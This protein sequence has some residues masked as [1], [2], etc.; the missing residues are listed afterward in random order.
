M[1]NVTKD[2]FIKRAKAVHGDKYD[3]SQVEYVN[4]QIPVTIVCPIHGSF[5]QR[6][7][8]HMLGRGCRKCGHIKRREKRVKTTSQF[9]EDARKVHGDKYDYS[10]VEYVNNYTDVK[11]VCPKHGV[12]SQIPHVH[13]YGCGCP[14]CR[15]VMNGENRKFTT[16]EFIHKA[17]MKHGDR[18]DYSKVIYSNEKEKVEIICKEHGSFW[19]TPFNHIYGRGCPKCNASSGEKAIMKWL[20]NEGIDYLYN[21]PIEGCEVNGNLLFFDFIIKGRNIAIEH[22]GGQHY[23]Q[24]WKNTPIET[25]RIRDQTKRD[26]CTSHGIRLIEIRYDEDIDQRLSQELKV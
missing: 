10:Q 1:G 20:E 9:I 15:D 16:E 2:D 4:T 17:K 5:L 13:L 14:K 26:F 23:R 11:I 12:F 21:E 8:D 24:S 3:Y 7:N 22:Q 19:Q 18:Y 25:Q 6:P